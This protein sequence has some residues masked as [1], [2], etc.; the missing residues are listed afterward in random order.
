M[1]D[2]KPLDA[3]THYRT[4]MRQISSSDL[5]TIIAF[6]RAFNKMAVQAPLTLTKNNGVLSIGFAGSILPSTVG[7]SEGMLL[8]LELDSS[9][10]KPT[11]GYAEIHA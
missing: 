10:L 7:K 2:T 5:N 11:Y 1:S 4:G 9:G 6:I 3:L 8:K